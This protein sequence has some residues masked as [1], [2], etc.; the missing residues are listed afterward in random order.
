MSFIPIKGDRMVAINKFFTP[1]V[2]DPRS[3]IDIEVG[4]MLKIT[5]VF[6][7]KNSRRVNI[8]RFHIIDNMYIS[9]IT[10]EVQFDMN[11]DSDVKYEFKLDNLNY[12]FSQKDLYDIIV[13]EDDFDLLIDTQSDLLK[14]YS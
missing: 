12:Y 5:D 8:D 10:H 6:L 14:Y 7:S 1:S 9:D 13:T 4:E 3:M 11:L 2:G